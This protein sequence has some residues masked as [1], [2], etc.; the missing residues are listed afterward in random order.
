[1]HLEANAEQGRPVYWDYAGDIRVVSMGELIETFDGL[2]P[3]NGL[4]EFARS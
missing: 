3:A 1:M 2:E 4:S